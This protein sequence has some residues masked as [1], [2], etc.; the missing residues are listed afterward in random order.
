M[1]K[2]INILPIE[3]ILNH[4]RDFEIQNVEEGGGVA[5]GGIRQKVGVRTGRVYVTNGATTSSF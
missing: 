2:K 3:T 4:K 1:V 5:K